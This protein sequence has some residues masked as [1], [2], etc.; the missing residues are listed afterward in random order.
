MD[1]PRCQKVNDD[2]LIRKRRIM[3]KELEVWQFIRQS[4]N[5]EIPVVL[6]IVADSRGSS[7]GRQGF[8]MAVSLDGERKGSIGGGIMEYQ[9]VKQATRL[10]ELNRL[11]PFLKKQIHRTDIIENRS[12]MICSGEQTVIVYPLQ[13]NDKDSV[14][15]IFNVLMNHKSGEF[16]LFPEGIRFDENR[17]LQKPFVLKKNQDM[18]GSMWK[19]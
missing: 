11:E 6:F 10:L 17:S 9:L 1:T 19:R 14:N 3:M 7:P 16:S 5:L 4:L 13:T 18:N 2:L 15:G 8:K 12:G